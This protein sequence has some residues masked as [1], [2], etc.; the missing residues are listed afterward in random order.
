M[1]YLIFKLSGVPEDEA[2]DVR[3]LLEENA[4][5]FYETTAGRWGVSMPGIWVH[6]EADHERSRG[7]IDQYQQERHS[8]FNEE[9]RKLETQGNLPSI[10]TNFLHNPF[11]LVLAVIAIAFVL[12]LTL[13][14]FLDLLDF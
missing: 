8:R 5:D 13:Y 2:D 7:L 12:G 11:R 3:H 6:D 14:P 4:I 9:W 1:P 10:W